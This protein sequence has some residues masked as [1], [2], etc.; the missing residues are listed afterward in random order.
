MQ[1]ISVFILLTAKLPDVSSEAETGS[2]PE[3][4]IR[5]AYQDG[6]AVLQSLHGEL[7]LPSDHVSVEVHVQLQVEVFGEAGGEGGEGAG[8]RHLD[9]SA[10][11]EH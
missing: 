4:R 11:T 2:V 8:V 3:H 6:E 9:P 7:D 1:I 10:E 5:A